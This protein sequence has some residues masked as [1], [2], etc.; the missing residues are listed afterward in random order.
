MSKILNILITGVGGPTPRSFAR[1]IKDIGNYSDYRLVATDIHAYA[2]GLYLFDL[3]DAAYITPKSSEPGYWEKIEK[4]IV[5]EEIDLAIIL[6]EQEVLAWSKKQEEGVLP[7]KALIPHKAAVDKM[8]DKGVLTQVLSK[9]GLVPHS[10]IIDINSQELK[11][12]TESKLLYP[13]W[14]RSA[15]GSSGLGSFKIE[16][17]EDLLKWIS[18]NKGITNFIASDYLPG[19]NL[20][21]KMLYFEGRLIRAACA[22]RIQYIMA[23]V[24]PSGITGNTSY[25][26]FINDK[27]VFQRSEKAMDIMFEHT[28]AL[29]HGF[30]T[31][32]LKEDAHGQPMITEINVRHVAFTQ[33]FAAAGANFCEDTVRLL[34]EDI[35]FNPHFQLYH[36]SEGLIFLRDVDERPIIMNEENLLSV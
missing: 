32:D 8:L 9:S 36:F 1:A 21:C 28:G 25:G 16:K 14:I 18:I 31:V 35:H 12:E 11:N 19:R 27:N 20:A 4:I 5:D 30:F 24:S 7:C 15:T 29:K 22:E 17:Y 23:K 6:P 10:V 2:I 26:R 34:D 3:F 13:Y 33:C